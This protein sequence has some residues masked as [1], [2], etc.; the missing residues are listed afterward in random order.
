MQCLV[1]GSDEVNE[2]E[3]VGSIRMCSMTH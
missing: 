2:S 1:L 3:T